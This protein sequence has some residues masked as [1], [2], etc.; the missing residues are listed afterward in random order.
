MQSRHLSR[1][2]KILVRGWPLL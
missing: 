1:V 2:S